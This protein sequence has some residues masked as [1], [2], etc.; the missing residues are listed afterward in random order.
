M[1][2]EEYK[3]AILAL[4][5]PQ[6]LLE[7]PT[8]FGKSKLG[9]DLLKQL[10]A[11]K[12]LIF[13]PKLPLIPNWKDELLKWKFTGDVVFSTYNSIHKHADHWDAVIFDE[14]QHYTERCADFVDND[15]IIDNVI[16]L[17]ATVPKAAR[18]R[19]YNSFPL[20]YRYK[21]SAKE[22]IDENILPDP[23]V[24]LLR[25]TLDNVLFTHK[26]IIN[27]KMGNEI[28]VKY[29][30]RWGHLRQKKYR[31][32]ILCTEVQYYSYISEK[33]EWF[34][35][36]YFRSKQDFMKN[37]WLQMSGERLKWLSSIK[38]NIVKQILLKCD[39]YRTLTFC[40]SIA[41]TED[42]GKFCINSQNGESEEVLKLFNEGKVNHITACNML[43]EGMNL[44]DCRVGIY[45]NLNSSEVIVKQRLG[46]LLRHKSPIIIIPYYQR[47]RDEEL[48]E[49]MMTDYNPELITRVHSVE[50]INL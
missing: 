22:A 5:K 38:N 34:K 39:N 44:V 8:S 1:T 13:V 30:Q 23:K 29:P 27:P 24:Y 36:S 47:T 18:E 3:Q 7:L 2:R 4:E 46:R 17:S 40:S 10:K 21:V 49:K 43:N 9:I 20:L 31:V 11:K 16:C 45:A 48:V 12:I 32:V 25:L 50:Q 41:Q 26:V 15:Y 14:C 28:T 33:I 6:V 42:L 19:L 35:N 37:R